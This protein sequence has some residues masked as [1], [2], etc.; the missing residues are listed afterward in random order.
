MIRQD[1]HRTTLPHGAIAHI[2]MSTD[3]SGIK[4]FFDG[5]G[6]PGER[7]VMF[8]P[9]EFDIYC[10]KVTFDAYI[11]HGKDVDYEAIDHLEYDHKNHTVEI[12]MK[13]GIVM[14]L[15]RKISWLVRPYLV[16][17]HQIQ[18]VKTKDHEAIDGTMKPLIHK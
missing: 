12:V 8:G 10:N 16:K 15:G 9:D 17:A 3:D 7:P 5:G 14:D 6:A 4:G 13:N 18:I 2:I 1:A 11:F